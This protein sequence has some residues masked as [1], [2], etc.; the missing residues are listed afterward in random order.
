M[1]ATTS[2]LSRRLSNPSRPC[3]WRRTLSRRT[4]QCGKLKRTR[5]MVSLRREGSPDTLLA[6]G[7]KLDLTVKTLGVSSECTS[8]R[9]SSR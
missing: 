2:I 6:S 3:S 8:L 4:C 5:E 7:K 1:E 9:K